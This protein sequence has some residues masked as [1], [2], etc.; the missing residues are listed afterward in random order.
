MALIYKQTWHPSR[1]MK[2]IKKKMG[3]LELK[4]LIIGLKIPWLGR[5]EVAEE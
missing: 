1:E 2:T 3:I 4:S 5:L